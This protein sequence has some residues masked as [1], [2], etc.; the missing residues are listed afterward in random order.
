MDLYFEEEVLEDH[1]KEKLNKNAPMG[2]R[3]FEVEKIKDAE[4]KKIFT[5][6]NEIKKIS[7][8]DIVDKKCFARRYSCSVAYSCRWRVRKTHCF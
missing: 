3:I 5:I 2:I 8:Q 1:I 7:R 6:Y 4:N